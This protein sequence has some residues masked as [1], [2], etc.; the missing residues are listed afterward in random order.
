MSM[1]DE[2]VAKSSEL[3]MRRLMEPV[4]SRKEI[5]KAEGILVGPLIEQDN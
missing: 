2:S 3:G 4:L 1:L 5:L